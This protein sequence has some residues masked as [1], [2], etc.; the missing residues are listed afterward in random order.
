MNIKYLLAPNIISNCMRP[1]P[2]PKVLERLRRNQ[3]QICTATVVIH[4]LLYGC[5]RLP[6][7]K[8]RSFFEQY[9]NELILNIPLFYY[10]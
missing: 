2:N 8:K 1:V 4:E 3:L 6:K 7:S 5:F 10:D 9:I